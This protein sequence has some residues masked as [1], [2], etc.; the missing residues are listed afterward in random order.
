MRTNFANRLLNAS[1]KQVQLLPVLSPEGT[2]DRLPDGRRPKAGSAARRATACR[3]DE[4][5]SDERSTNRRL[6]LPC[7]DQPVAERIFLG[8]LALSSLAGLSQ[9][10]AMVIE[11]SGHW[12]ALEAS[13]NRLIG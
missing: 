7:A 6:P 10:L 1:F 11:S 12:Y 8:L 13:V 5:D 2:F 4:P 3:L 9:A